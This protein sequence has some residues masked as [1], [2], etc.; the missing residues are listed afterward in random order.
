MTQYVGLDVFVS[1]KSRVFTRD[2]PHQ[3]GPGG[4]WSSPRTRT[5]AVLAS[6]YESGNIKRYRRSAT[7]LPNC[8]RPG[9]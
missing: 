3:F 7:Q 4:R 9:L 5:A 6:G 8:E 1:R 2:D